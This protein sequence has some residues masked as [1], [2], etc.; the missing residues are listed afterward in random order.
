MGRQVSIH[1]SAIVTVN[2][3]IKPIEYRLILVYALLLLAAMIDIN[4]RQL[5]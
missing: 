4:V 5:S 2:N 1:S 3:S